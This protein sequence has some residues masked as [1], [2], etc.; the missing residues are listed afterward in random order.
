[1]T[2]FYLILYFS[3]VMCELAPTS[4]HLGQFTLSQTNLKVSS[5]S[6][7]FQ[8]NHGSKRT[9]IKSKLTIAAA[10]RLFPDFSFRSFAT[11]L[12][13]IHCHSGDSVFLWHSLYLFLTSLPKSKYCLTPF[14]VSPLKI[15][16][17]E[18]RVKELGRISSRLHSAVCTLYL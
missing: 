1:M 3:N 8:L 13:H 14:M 4:S 16:V 2:D 9:D 6:L 17:S 15:S 10:N 5:I 11:L 7:I 12:Q 18:R